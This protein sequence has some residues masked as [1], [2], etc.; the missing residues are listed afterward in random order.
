MLITLRFSTQPRENNF[1]SIEPFMEHVNK[2]NSMVLSYIT[3]YPENEKKN[4][5]K[6]EIEVKFPLCYVV[7]ETEKQAE[8]EKLANELKLKIIKSNKDMPTN[9]LK[10]KYDGVIINLNAPKN[11]F[12]NE[13]RTNPNGMG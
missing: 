4:T 13:V 1:K 5:N 11:T 10:I 2:F 6:I 3:I 9:E 7:F 8:V 12:S